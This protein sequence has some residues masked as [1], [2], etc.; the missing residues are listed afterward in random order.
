MTLSTV[1]CQYLYSIRLPPLHESPMDIDTFSGSAAVSKYI[2][3]GCCFNLHYTSFPFAW[4]L[5]LP[6]PSVSLLLSVSLSDR[7]VGVVSRSDHIPLA[8]EFQ[9]TIAF[10]HAVNDAHCIQ[11]KN[12]GLQLHMF[13]S[14]ALSVFGQ[15]VWVFWTCSSRLGGWW[16]RHATD[17]DEVH[18]LKI[19]IFY[20]IQLQ[21]ESK[22][23]KTF[24][25]WWWCQSW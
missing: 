5:V 9:E 21:A 10:S 6:I 8:T 3:W 15:Y 17:R 12:G 4:Q 23:I 25:R 7:H 22:V 2:G 24:W 13:S 20:L 14:A 19:I 1:C 16:I 11:N 18:R